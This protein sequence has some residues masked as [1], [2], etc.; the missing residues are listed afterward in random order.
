MRRFPHRAAVSLAIAAALLATG[1]SSAAPAASTS[2]AQSVLARLPSLAT[3]RVTTAGTWAVAVMGGSAATHNNFWQLFVRPAGKT[4]WRLVTPPGVADNGGLVLADTGGKSLVTAFR[5]SQ[6]LAYTPITVTRDSGKAWSSAGLLDA[7][8]AD[9]PDALAADP[10]N[11]RLLALL[12]SGTAKLAGPGYTRWT[13]LATRRSLAATPAGRR[14]AL[15]GLTAA[16]FTASGMPLL[17][18]T[19]S[20]PGTVGIFGSLGGT[21]QAAGPKLPAALAHQAITVLRLTT[22]GKTTTALL[23]AGTGPAARLLAGWSADGG[24]HWKL[25]PSLPLNGATLTSA[26]SGPENSLAITLSHRRAAAITGAAGSW[27]PLPVLPPGTAT[28]APGPSGG[29]NALAVHGTQLTIWQAARGA[30]AWASAQVIKV[31][32]QFGSSG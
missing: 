17:A 24:A 18:G 15:G 29:W 31:P 26:S 21:W 11:G 1:C 2:A 13:T 14:C 25:S 9:A 10:A 30:Q 20:H 6:Y 8:L 28:L 23:A 3:S 4:G 12:T 7:A 27:R 19:C 5:P 32:V 22:T 16:V